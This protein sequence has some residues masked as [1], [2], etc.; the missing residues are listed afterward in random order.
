MKIW[1]Y[2]NFS[3]QLIQTMHPNNIE[4][5]AMIN[6]AIRP[7]GASYRDALTKRQKKH[8]ANPNVDKVLEK[9]Y[10]F[11][12]FQEDIMKFLQEICGFSGSDSDNIRRAIGTFVPFILETI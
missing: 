5:L 11:M 3:G 9:T 6:A 4:E 10:Y 8:T 1:G 7:A 2:M 12:V